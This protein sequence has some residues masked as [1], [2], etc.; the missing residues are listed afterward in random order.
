MSINSTVMSNNTM[1]SSTNT[2]ENEM[3]TVA[4][5]I[6]QDLHKVND[7]ILEYTEGRASL[8]PLLSNYLVHSGGKRM[9]PLLT[10]LAAKLCGYEGDRHIRL[11]AAVEFIHT[12]TL[13]HDDVVD[14]SQLRR[15]KPTANNVWGN[16]AS[17]LV[18]DFLLSQAFRLMVKDGSLKILDILS[19]ASG[20]IAEGEVKQLLAVN[21]LQLTVVDYIDIVRSKTA[22]LF[23]AACQIGPY[24]T[25]RTLYED[26]A[27][28]TYGM[29]LGIAFQIID[30]V[31]DYL[32]DQE[33]LGKRIGDDFREGKVTLPIIYAYQ[34][35]GQ[36]EKAFWHRTFVKGE[37]SEED[38]RHAI[39][40]LQEG[41]Y[42]IQ[43]MK[44]ATKY[45]ED[46]RRALFPFPYS[47]EKRALLEVLDFSLRRMY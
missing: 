43:A 41:G 36:E 45:I 30:D 47:L 1:V 44:D 8:I 10:L 23:A 20:V 17:I 5:L 40:L 3:Q 22:E 19:T 18:G 13:L 29:N 14:D 9:R 2:L 39:K 31:L 28:K 34:T 38:L 21:N 26:K 46:A 27:M 7:V 37:R 24:L 11:A 42:L 6:G 16:K 32:A 12:A 4:Q 15:N 25:D 33:A 35:A